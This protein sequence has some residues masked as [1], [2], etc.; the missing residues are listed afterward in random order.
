MRQPLV[1]IAILSFSLT[2][3]SSAS[4]SEWVPNAMGNRVTGETNWWPGDVRHIVAMGLAAQLRLTPEV[5]MDLDFPW[6]VFAPDREDL[7]F[8]STTFAFGNPSIGIHWAGRLNEDL[9]IHAGGT[10]TVATLFRDREDF[11]A[12]VGDGNGDLDGFGT[13]LEGARVRA[14]AD[15]HRFLPD[16]IFLRG[17]AGV[18]LRVFPWLYYRAEITPMLGIAIVT[19]SADFFM[20]IHNE[21]EARGASGL[22]GGLHLQAVFDTTD[23]IS[24]KDAAQLALEPY[25]VFD[26]GRGTYARVGILV[27]LDEP[28]GF[29]LDAGRVA[30]IC[31]TLGGRW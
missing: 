10:L 28:L 7:Q 25:F 20:D 23:D 29:G 9:M 18:E 5:F 30:S 6:A 19:D 2:F 16:Y 1:S 31:I 26:R 15:V 4:G 21:I 14:L 3:S 12:K 17:R 24:W 13:R 8:A 22:G 11:S 27:A